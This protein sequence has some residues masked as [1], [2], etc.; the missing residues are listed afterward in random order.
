MLRTHSLPGSLRR[1]LEPFRPCFTTPTFV[2]FTVL[3]AGMIARPTHRT[4]CG[5][6]TGAGL[7]RTWRHS[8]THRFFTAARGNPD[9]VGLVV[10]RLITGWLIPVG[11]PLVVAIDDTMFRRSGRWVHAAHWGYDGSLKV[12]KY[13]KRLSRG[14]SFVVAAVL[15]DLPFLD[16]PVALPALMRLWHKG[17]P[18][19]TVLAHQLVEVIA[20]AA[21]ERI[22]HVVADGACICKQRGTRRSLRTH[23]PEHRDHLVPPGRP[24]PRRGPRT[25]PL[26]TL[27]HHQDLPVVRRHDRQAPAGAHRRPFPT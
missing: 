19:K 6:L 23:H 7:A 26:R 15:V 24:P 17:G 4:V 5:M 18:T 1:A 8:R 2:T 3:V 14:N 10:L 25:P 16:R 13:G 9:A 21:G 12:P 11:A 20:A 27:V 22:V